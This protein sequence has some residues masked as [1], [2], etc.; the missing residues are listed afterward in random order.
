[1]TPPCMLQSGSEAETDAIAR[2]LAEGVVPGLVVALNGDLGAG[3]TRF[4]RGLATWLGVDE[5]LVNSPTY[6]IIQHY[7]GKLPIH[8]FDLYRLRDADEW[9]ELGAEELLESDGICLIEWADRFPDV[10]PSD[11][12]EIRFH[13]TGPDTRTLEITAGG[14][15]SASVFANLRSKVPQFLKK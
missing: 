9:D 14:P 10:L 4:T 7:A 3:K 13:T 6:V 11:H 5:N 15:C 2:A 1:M 8:H 12:L